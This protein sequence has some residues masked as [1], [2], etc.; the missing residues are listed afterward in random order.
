MKTGQGNHGI[1]LFPRDHGH[2]R[3]SAVEPGLVI[4]RPT[5]LYCFL[6]ACNLETH[7]SASN[8]TDADDERSN[9]PST[10]RAR[11]TPETHRFFDRGPHWAT[12][13]GFDWVPM[14][15][16]CE[17]MPRPMGRMS[18][19]RT[20]KLLPLGCHATPPPRC[21]RGGGAAGRSR[22]IV[23]YRQ[24][25]GGFLT[26]PPWQ[27]CRCWPAPMIPGLLSP[28]P[29]A[30]LRTMPVSLAHGGSWHG[31]RLRAMTDSQ[32]DLHSLVA[33][34]SDRPFATVGRAQRTVCELCQGQPHWP[35]PG[36]ARRTSAC[37]PPARACRGWP[38][39]LTAARPSSN[40]RYTQA[41]IWRRRQAAAARCFATRI[42]Y[43]SG[44][45]ALW[46]DHHC[47]LAGMPARLS[48]ATLGR[49]GSMTPPDSRSNRGDRAMSGDVKRRDFLMGAGCS[50]A[51]GP[52]WTAPS[53]AEPAPRPPRKT[54]LIIGAHYDDCEIGA[55]RPDLQG[56]Q[57]GA[58]R[59]V[60]QRGGQL[61]H[62]V[63]HQGPRGSHPPAER[64]SRPGHGCRE[65]LYLDFGYQQVMDDLPTLRKIAEVV[66][67]VKPNIT[68]MTDRNERARAPSDHSK[69]GAL[70]EQAVLTP[71]RSWA[72]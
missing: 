67:D 18:P 51:W 55:R 32:G 64:G 47:R 11:D 56:G 45:N 72:G 2:N 62:L 53:A 39:S 66:V 14:P 46:K 9:V 38:P 35:L 19:A 16:K 65:A 10:H 40:V 21:E 23:G 31:T 57:E 26:I 17:G 20:R 7:T 27:W 1:C 33:Q 68:L 30:M 49:L 48:A 70:A 52:R 5:L 13:L 28:G 44:V 69:V 6:A 42:A 50:P 25:L 3:I 41:P 29:V 54:L 34:R 43:N 36:A 12:V 59:R 58:P 71:I 22:G 37:N 63:R 60:T 15:R 24:R 61:L 8:N 4:E